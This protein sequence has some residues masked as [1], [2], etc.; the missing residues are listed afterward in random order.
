MLGVLGEDALF[1]CHAD[2]HDRY[3][4]RSPVRK[5][6]R[7]WNYLAGLVSLQPVVRR[8]P[9]EQLVIVSLWIILSFHVRGG[10][11]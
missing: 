4:A 7:G 8:A 6:E 1:V 5:D 3:L 2:Q 9:P 11:A 10:V